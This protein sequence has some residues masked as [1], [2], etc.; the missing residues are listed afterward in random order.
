VYTR[1][2]CYQTYDVQLFKIG[3]SMK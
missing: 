2:V 3:N 1:V